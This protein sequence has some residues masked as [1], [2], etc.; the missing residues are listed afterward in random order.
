LVGLKGVSEDWWLKGVVRVIVRDGCS[1]RVILG[2]RR[3]MDCGGFDEMEKV[4]LK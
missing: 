2:I 4:T 3:G 1:N